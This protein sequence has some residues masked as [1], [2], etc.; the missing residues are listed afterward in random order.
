MLHTHDY[1]FELLSSVIEVEQPNRRPVI[2]GQIH[3]GAQSG[4]FRCLQRGFK[5]VTQVPQLRD[6]VTLRAQE[7]LEGQLHCVSIEVV[8]WDEHLPW[9]DGLRCLSGLPE[10]V[11]ITPKA[12]GRCAIDR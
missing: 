8:A 12:E 10:L 3:E 6:G 4:T 11:S 2:I 5:V 1:V 7:C 9:L